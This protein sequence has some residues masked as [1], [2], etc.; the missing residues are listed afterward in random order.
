MDNGLNKINQS[1]QELMDELVLL[2]EQAKQ[3]IIT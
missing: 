3:Q 2:I 1:E